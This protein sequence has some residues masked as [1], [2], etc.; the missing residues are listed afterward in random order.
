MAAALE[1]RLSTQRAIAAYMLASVGMVVAN[2]QTVSTLRAGTVLLALQMA[3][4][5]LA[6]LVLFACGLAPI[7]GT[8]SAALRWAPTGIL[9]GLLLWAGMEAVK[10]ASLSTLTVLRNASPMFLLAAE[11]AAFGTRPT[12]GKA[13]S[14]LVILVGVCLYTWADLQDANTDYRGIIFV[15]LDAALVCLDSLLERYLLALNPVNLSTGALVL[16]GN[17]VGLLPVA[18]L[19]LGPCAGEWAEL[20]VD[21]RGSMWG[22]ATLPGGVAMAYLGLLLRRVVSATGAVVVSNVDKVVVLL[23][24]ILCM[25]DR[26]DAWKV[27]GCAL[28]LVGGAWHAVAG[29]SAA[30]CRGTVQEISWEP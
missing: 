23:Y 4:T 16:V 25:G 22:L 19:L 10:H 21:L 26:M 12:L 2:K 11:W 24:G 30:P 29:S 15:L 1:P 28:A 8:A 9:S 3:V 6:V 14:L 7:E 18:V 27:S 20:H 5:C 13:A 17:A